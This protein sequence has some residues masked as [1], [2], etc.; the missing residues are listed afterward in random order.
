VLIAL[1]FAWMSGAVGF[2]RRHIRAINIMGG[3]VLVVIGL[4]MV[5]GVWTV[6]IYE[7]QSVMATVQLPV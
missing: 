1:G 2:L 4:L 3:S 6:L 7:L 5:T